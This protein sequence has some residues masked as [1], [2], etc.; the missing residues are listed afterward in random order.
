MMLKFTLND[1]KVSVDTDENMPLLW[2]L[3]DVLGKTG[4]KFGCGQGLCGACTVHLDGQP[5]RACVLPISSVANKAVTTIEGL[6]EDAQ[7]PVQKAWAAHNVPQC[8]YCQSGQMMSAAALLAQNSQPSEADKSLTKKVKSAGDVLD[9]AV[10]DHII[11]TDHKYYSF[12]DESI[13][14]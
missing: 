12:A 11:F 4:T 6:S 14:P 3:R 13:M 7:H 1:K 8:G 9:I 5:V 10:L 2:V